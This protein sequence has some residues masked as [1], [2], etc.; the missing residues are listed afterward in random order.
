M[1][2]DSNNS[3]V[4]TLFQIGTVAKTLNVTRKMILN[5]EEHD[6][7]TPATKDPVTGYRYYTADNMTQIQLIRS[8]QK[9]GLSLEEIKNYLVGSTELNVTISRLEDLR[10]QIDMSISKLYIRANSSNKL[11]YYW[12]TLPHQKSYSKEYAGTSL[13]DRTK[14]LRDAY[15]HVIHHHKINFENG[16]MFSELSLSD[17]SQRNMYIPVDES[18]SGEGISI[19]PEITAICVC[20]KGPY[21]NLES[22]ANSLLE[23]I[24]SKQIQPLG[25]IRYIYLEGPPNRGADKDSYLT[26]IAIPVKDIYQDIPRR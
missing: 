23:F 18:C 26:I 5:Y 16:Y 21:E 15:L 17:V 25:T 13:A 12:T 11:D 3:Y 19:T 24:N 22:I 20:Y 6:L 9:Y 10:N 1:T 4:P 14:E 8:F 2:N 7:L